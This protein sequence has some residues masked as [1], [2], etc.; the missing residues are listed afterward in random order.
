MKRIVM[1][2]CMMCIHMVA[3]QPQCLFPPAEGS[4]NIIIVRVQHAATVPNDEYIVI[5]NEG[6]ITIDLSGWV[7]FNEHYKEYQDLP[8]S[9]RTDKSAWRH[10]Y[11]IPYGFKLKPKYWVRISSGHGD[12]NEMYLYRN[13]AEQWLTDEGDTVYLMDEYC[14]II[15]ENS[16]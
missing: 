1:I 13:L 7:V 4:E 3:A 14:N 5:Y 6:D 12:N 2:V 8:A 10:I 9:E 15:S 11:K 16:W